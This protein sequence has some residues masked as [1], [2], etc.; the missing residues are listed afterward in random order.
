MPSEWYENGP[1]SAIEDLQ[2]GRPIIG[3]NIGGI[4]ELVVDNGY[5][6][7][8]GIVEDLVD[9]L[10]IFEALTQ[11]EYENFEMKSRQIS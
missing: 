11:Q 1:H 8:S 9:Y 6:F 5:L 4:P 10:K 2:L 3:A 7:R